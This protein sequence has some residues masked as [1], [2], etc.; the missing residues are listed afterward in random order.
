[1]SLS[2][3][4]LLLCRG[5]HGAGWSLGRR[6]PRRGRRGGALRLA[7]RVGG[8]AGLTLVLQLG[9]CGDRRCLLGGTPLAEVLIDPLKEVYQREEHADWS[10]ESHS[11]RAAAGSLHLR[12]S[13]LAANE[14]QCLD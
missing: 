14:K 7:V 2:L 6:V 12:G 8:G 10:S 11:A 5:A 9:A 3:L 4:G 13:E 1:M